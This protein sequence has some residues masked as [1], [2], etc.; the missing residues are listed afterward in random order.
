MPG[1][2]A[3]TPPPCGRT[4]GSARG[5]RAKCPLCAPRA[6]P[7]TRR[8]GLAAPPG[9][10]MASRVRGPCP[11][12]RR[13]SLTAGGSALTVPAAACFTATG[14]FHSGSIP[15]LRQR[16][17][18][19]APRCQRGGQSALTRRAAA[20]TI[21]RA[22]S[23]NGS[24][25]GSPTRAPCRR[26]TRWSLARALQPRRDRCHPG[27]VPCGKRSSEP[28][29]MWTSSAKA[30]SGSL[31]PPTTIWIGSGARTRRARPSGRVL[32]LVCRSM[33]SR[34]AGGSVSWTRRVGLTGATRQRKFAS[35]KNSMTR[36]RAE[37]PEL[38]DSR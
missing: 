3:G 13:T 21:A 32:S 34:P 27:G 25:L 22:S 10:A 20:R 26:S 4:Q 36:R 16:G 24:D 7:R 6:R 8:P 18:A 2:H 19:A 12:P 35:S 31:H 28:A 11:R 30:R 37:G 14:R 15:R 5:L 29:T 33:S 1:R 38:H 23:P 9:R 17:L